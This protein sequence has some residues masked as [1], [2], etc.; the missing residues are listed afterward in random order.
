MKEIIVKDKGVDEVVIIPDNCNHP[1]INPRPKCR[2]IN[3]R[4]P[5][6]DCRWCTFNKEFLKAG[7][8]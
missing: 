6:C 5:E 3:Q 2:A 4:Q 8:L 1:V 7:E